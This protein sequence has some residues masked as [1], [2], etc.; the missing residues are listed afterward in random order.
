MK[1]LKA[2]EEKLTTLKDSQYETHQNLRNYQYE[3]KTIYS[4]IDM[5]LEKNF[6]RQEELWKNQD[7][8]QSLPCMMDAHTTYTILS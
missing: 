4:N 6:Y 5:I 1:F 8:S 7:I 2:E 3:L